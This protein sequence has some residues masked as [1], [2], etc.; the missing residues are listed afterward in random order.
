MAYP[1]FT[2]GLKNLCPNLE[3]PEESFAA[4]GSIVG[5]T[6][7][8]LVKVIEHKEQICT[9]HCWPHR[10]ISGVACIFLWRLVVCLELNGL[11]CGER[12]L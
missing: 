1:Q 3:L 11:K 4:L 10:Q 9:R 6:L 2:Q 7:S 8:A 5:S 12:G